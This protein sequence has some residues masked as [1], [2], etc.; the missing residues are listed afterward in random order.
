MKESHKDLNDL[1]SIQFMD[2]DMECERIDK[3]NVR[4]R[5]LHGLKREVEINLDGLCDDLVD[6]LGQSAR[7]VFLL[8]Y[9]LGQ[10][11]LTAD[12]INEIDKHGKKPGGEIPKKW[13]TLLENDPYAN[14]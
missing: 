14:N 12:I 9:R 4:I 8:G 6:L 10:I 1:L 11:I 5:E 2:R 7:G 3:T 13:P